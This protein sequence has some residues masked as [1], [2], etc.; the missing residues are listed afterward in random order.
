MLILESCPQE[1]VSASDGQIVLLQATDLAQSKKLIPDA[2]TWVQ[3]FSLYAAVLI[4]KSP[5]R[6]PSLLSYMAT[7]CKFSK[8]YKWPSYIIY[9]EQF[10]QE[11]AETGKSDWS[12]TDGGIHSYCF[13]GQCIDTSPWCSS[14]KTLDHSSETCLVKQSSSQ[15]TKLSG[16]KRPPKKRPP[17]GSIQEPCCKWN[18]QDKP[19]CPFEEACIYLHVCQTCKQ[20]DHPESACQSSGKGCQACQLLNSARTSSPSHSLKKKKKKKKVF[21]TVTHGFVLGLC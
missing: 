3:C 6:A 8:R 14:C 4:A 13:N 5:E 2:A 11:A 19:D 10:R 18:K 9:D 7:I 1:R 16:A 15:S 20:P 12:K 21:F 17:P